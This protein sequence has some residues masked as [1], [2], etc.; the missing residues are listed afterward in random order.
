MTQRLLF[1]IALLIGSNAAFAQFYAPD[2]PLSIGIYGGI[3]PTTRIYGAVDYTA[4]EKSLPNIFGVV[5]HYNIT[6]RI[7]VGLD[8]GTQSEWSARGITTLQGTNG[9]TLGQPGIR[10]VYAD[11]VW[12]GQLRFNA[13]IPVYDRL[14]TVRSNFYY[15]VGVGAIFTVNDGGRDYRQFNDQ[16]GE[17]YRFVSEYRYEPAA[18]Y[19]VGFQVGMEWWTNGRLGVN[20]EFAPRFNHLNAVDNRYSGRN[21]P[22]DVFTFPILGGIRYRF[23]SLAR[24]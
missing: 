19:T 12:T 2:Y 11:R 15:G 23:G 18:G 16:L 9:N 13:L 1:V 17:E 5:G 22:F 4:D 14:K 3:A 7:Q 8:V 24:Y 10:Y 20:V 21:G 6:D